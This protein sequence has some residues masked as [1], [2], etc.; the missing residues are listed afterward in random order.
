MDV[1]YLFLSIVSLCNHDRPVARHALYTVELFVISEKKSTTKAS[2]VLW[3]E[4]WNLDPSWPD[5]SF[6]FVSLIA[7]NTIKIRTSSFKRHT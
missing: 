2:E 3:I 6:V 4:I 7:W 1:S 5:Q